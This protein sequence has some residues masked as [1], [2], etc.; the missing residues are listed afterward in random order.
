MPIKVLIVDDSPLMRK[1]LT[2][3]V[4]ASTDIEVVGTASDPIAAWE[5]IKGLNP[6]VLTL[7]VEMSKTGGLEF[8]SR[9]TRLKPMPVVMISS[10]T[11]LGSE[12]SLQAQAL[13]VVDFVAKPQAE[14]LAALH[15]FGDEVRDKV[16]AAYAMSRQLSSR[17]QEHRGQAKDEGVAAHL[18]TNILT[19]KVIAL[20]ASTG[21]TEAI[22]SVLTALPAE[23]PPI[24]MV[25]HMPENFT[26]SFAQRLNSLSR[27]TVIE[28]KGG[29]RLQPGHAYLAPGH[30]HLLVRRDGGGAM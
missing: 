24:V 26:P 17:I 11:A 12:A 9:L 18:C 16:R 21:G 10:L 14:N 1:L 2:E 20:G 5:M 28:A 19:E 7:D 22:K 29:E 30:S 15:G 6:D 4:G 25:Q 23:M 13:G 3:I 27:L 8:L